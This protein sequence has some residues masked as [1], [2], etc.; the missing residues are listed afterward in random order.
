MSCPTCIA[1]RALLNATGRIPE[2]LSNSIAYS[3]PIQSLD[4]GIKTVVKKKASA[5]NRRYAT[6]FR[7]LKKSHTLATGKYR[8]GW[9][10]KKLVKA[11]HKVAKR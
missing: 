8:K 1:I 2:P 3:T 9:N 7:K 11:A 10:F 5:Y 6:A 4:A